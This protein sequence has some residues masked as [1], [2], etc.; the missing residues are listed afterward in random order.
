MRISRIMIVHPTIS[1]MHLNKDPFVYPRGFKA[2]GIDTVL[3]V[4]KNNLTK[5]IPG[6][7]KILKLKNRRYN[8]K[9]NKP[10]SI[11][12]YII[13]ELKCAKEI[14]NTAK[15]ERADAI[16]FYDDPIFFVAIKMLNRMM[17]I[18]WKFDTD[19]RIEELPYSQTIAKLSYSIKYAFSNVAIIASNDA[20]KRVL[21]IF[22]YFKRKLKFI[23]NGILNNFFASN[24]HTAKRN[25]TILSVARVAK[26]KGYDILIKSFAN[27]KRNKGWNIRIIG[28]IEERDYYRELLALID[29]LKLKKRVKFLGMVS[30][31]QRYLRIQLPKSV[32]N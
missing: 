25:K 21:A 22:P 8:I 29:K 27:I 18:I 30:E 23:P 20:Y 15:K 10:S 31:K 14:N 16:M 19:G 1:D 11:F 4:D 13:D 2:L 28:P 26:V 24:A 6:L 3:L 5:T 17:P 9:L 7:P 12:R 32:L